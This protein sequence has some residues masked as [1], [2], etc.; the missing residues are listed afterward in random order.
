MSRRDSCGEEVLFNPLQFYVQLLLSKKD[1]DKF[2]KLES[3]SA[4]QRA[5]DSQLVLTQ[6]SQ[7][8]HAT[9]MSA[10]DDEDD[11]GA[12]ESLQDRIQGCGLGGFDSKMYRVRRKEH[13]KRRLGTL[14]L[15]LARAAATP[16][17]SEEITGDFCVAMAMYKLVQPASRPQ[18]VW[19][20]S[21]TNQPTKSVSVKMD[22]N[23]AAVLDASQ[24]HT[25]VEFAGTPNDMIMCFDSNYLI[26]YHIWSAGGQQTHLIPMTAAQ[27]RL[28]KSGAVPARRAP[29]ADGALSDDSSPALA[30]LDGEEGAA[31]EALD[32]SSGLATPYIDLL[33]FIDASALHE[34]MQFKESLFLF[35]DE[36]TITGSTSAFRSLLKQMST[37]GVVGVGRMLR[38]VSEQRLVAL[39][40]RAETIDTDGY[41]EKAGGLEVIHLPF[42]QE[43]R[44]GAIAS[45]EFASNDADVR[46]LHSAAEDL[47]KSLTFGP[48]F[49]YSDLESPGLQYFYAT[50]QAIALAEDH[51]DWEASRDDMLLPDKDSF[52]AH[53]DR[54]VAFVG[55]AGL[56]SC[57]DGSDV[58]KSTVRNITI[59]Y[60]TSMCINLIS[61]ASS[62]HVS[63]H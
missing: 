4:S 9:N 30:G 28:L 62:S 37:K 8:Q 2:A 56:P 33:Y 22:T 19:L 48:S 1:Y 59:L 40:P 13:K 29:A 61:T 49:R 26:G 7:T 10:L 63:A 21:L 35:P 12:V 25:S 31:E 6:W 27:M 3:A 55:A 47:V 18:Y 14:T 24:I 57:S 38:G 52:A 42:T 44:T 23:S 58:V 20:H 17:D 50:L 34:D 60:F 11:G 54:L 51:C 43:V 36:N 15:R 46:S 32:P 5:S 53:E 16:S 45:A 39:L 41:L